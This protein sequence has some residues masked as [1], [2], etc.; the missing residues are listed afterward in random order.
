MN[1]FNRYYRGVRLVDIVAT[2]AL[3]ALITS[4]YFG[5]TIAGGERSEIAQVERQ[6]ED[7]QA[8]IRLLRAEVT[9]LENPS[10]LGSL[11]ASHLGLA[12]I[13][14]AKETTPDGLAAALQKAPVS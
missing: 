7:E 12:P 6:I 2:G 1:L 4:L 13:A 5:K 10:R 14:A 9:H 11:S 3:I 8:R